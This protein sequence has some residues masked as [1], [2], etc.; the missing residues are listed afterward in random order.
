MPEWFI[1]L[2]LRSSSCVMQQFADTFLDFY[3]NIWGCWRQV[4]KKTY[5][6]MYIYRFISRDFLNY[7]KAFV[8][9]SK[10]KIM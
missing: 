3:G 4:N 6:N 2:S 1:T 10:I 8:I 9:L 7:Y 5:A